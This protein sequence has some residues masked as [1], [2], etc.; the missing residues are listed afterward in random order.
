MQSLKIIVECISIGMGEVKFLGMQKIICPNFINIARKTLVRQTFFLHIFCTLLAHSVCLWHIYWKLE[1]VVLEISFLI[2]QQRKSS[3]GYAKTFSEARWLST[4]EHFPRS[5]LGV[6]FYSHSS[7][8]CHQGT[9]HPAEVA[10]KLLPSLKTCDICGIYHIIYIMTTPWF[11][12]DCLFS[13]TY[14]QQTIWQ[15]MFIQI[16]SLKQRLFCTCLVWT[17]LTL[18]RCPAIYSIP[19]VYKA[20][21]CNAF[22]W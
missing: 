5:S 15:N 12:Q 1:N 11:S 8:S 3:V 10:L 7:Y 22:F 14:M 4:L 16:L 21:K 18:I 17:L 2:I 20:H 19:S 13:C 6:A 9:S